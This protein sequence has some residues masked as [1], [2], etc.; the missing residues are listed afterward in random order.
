MNGGFVRRFNY[1]ARNFNQ[2]MKRLCHE[3]LAKVYFIDHGFHQLPPTSN[4]CL[5]MAEPTGPLT[6]LAGFQLL[7]RLA[8]EVNSIHPFLPQQRKQALALFR[9]RTLTLC[10]RPSP[11]DPAPSFPEPDPRT[12]ARVIESE[13]MS[14]PTQNPLPSTSLAPSGPSIALSS[15]EFPSLPSSSSQPKSG[16]RSDLTTDP[17]PHHRYNLRSSF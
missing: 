5:D 7:L 3:D 11:D 9:H 2:E 15:E 13:P 16:V 1:E 14:A 4:L 12:P 8:Q 10:L 6:G 17:T